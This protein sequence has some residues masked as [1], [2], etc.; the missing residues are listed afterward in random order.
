MASATLKFEI[1]PEDVRRYP[2]AYPIVT[3]DG[4]VHYIDRRQEMFWQKEEYRR[5][6]A[7]MRAA[8]HR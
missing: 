2:D 4:R 7:A 5:V 8:A 6:I 3:P 1:A